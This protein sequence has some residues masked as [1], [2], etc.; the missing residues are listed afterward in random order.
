MYNCIWSMKK[1]LIVFNHPAPYKVRLFNELSKVFDLHVI[2]ERKSASDR[3]KKFYFEEDYKFKT[4]DI[5]GIRLGRENILSSGVK[6]HLKHNTYDLVIMNGYSTF[7]E[8]K[9]INYLKRHKIPYVFYINGGTIREKEGLLKKVIKTHYIKGAKM[10]FSPDEESNKYLVYYGADKNKIQNY[11][12]STIY[13]NEIAKEN[14]NKVELRKKLGLNFDKVFVSSGQLIERKNYVSLVKEWIS[15]PKD[16][17]LVLIGDGKERKQI[18]SIIKENKLDNVILKGFLPREE[19]FEYFKASDAFLF[20]SHEDIYG[21]VINE[22]LSQGIPVVSTNK[23]NSA[24]K[25]I[26]PNQ[27]G[28][29]LDSLT[30]VSLKLAIEKVTERSLFNACINTANENTVEKMAE[31]HVEMINEAMK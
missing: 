11:P 5:K 29:L 26:K 31:R 18:E 10:Y 15:F 2:F 27:N 6:K 1:I 23:V 4:H 22:A 30:G 3:D 16:N 19:M 20:P 9:A 13:E 24:V 28:E 21:H 25:L 7:A 17:A 12:Y 14:V 8:M